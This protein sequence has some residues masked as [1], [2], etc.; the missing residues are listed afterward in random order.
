[1]KNRWSDST[2]D[3]FKARYGPRFG[4]ELALRTYTSRLIGAEPALVLHGGGNTSL[5][6][7]Q[8]DVFGDEL[9]ALF[10]KASGHDLANIEPEGHV[11]VKLAPLQRMRALDDLDDAS[12]EAELR[13]HL[14]DSRAPTPS[15]ETPVHALIPERFVDHAHA[16]AILALTNQPDGEARVA[17]ALGPNVIVLPYVFAGFRLS[18]LVADAREKHPQAVGMIWMHHGIVTW[19]DSARESY[20]RM[21]E[22][23]SRAEAVLE[24]QR[25]RSLTARRHTSLDEAHERLGR[26]APLLRGRLAAPSGDP[27]RP[28]RRVLLLPLVSREV[29]DL[30]DSEGARELC[31]SPPLTADHLIRTKPLPL[32]IDLPDSADERD[33]CALIEEAIEAYAD[34]YRAYLDRHAGSMPEG[35][36]PFDALPR[37][38]LMPGIGAL[39]VGRDARSAAIARDITAQT[40]AAKERITAM[41]VEYR[42]LSEEHLFE[43]E[44]RPLQRAKLPSGSGPALAGHVVLVTGAAGAI[45]SGICEGLLAEGAH[46]VAT[47]LAGPALDALVEKLDAE[48]PGRS[49]GV[50]VDV[51]DPDSVEAGFDA[52]S[53]TWGGV[54]Q[55]IIN[56]GLA[57]VAA[58]EE[59]DLARFQL[60]Q[61]VNTEGALLLLGSAGRRLKQQGTGGDIVLVSTKNVFA[62]GARFGAYSATKAAAHQLARIASQELAE[63]DVRVNMV[64]PDAVFSHGARSSGLWAEVGPDRMQARGLDAAGLEEYYRN[65]NLLQ[66]QIRADHVANAVLFFL[67]RRTPTTGA[68]IPV[69]GGLPDATPR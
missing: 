57:H 24:G 39:C 40:L 36:E 58:L 52:A 5:K 41:G 44:Y 68:T 11:A 25:C 53:R 13:C 4:D 49:V 32:W 18:K 7:T 46:V 27:D 14:F 28:H 45:G 60:L 64:A 50:P 16:D 63:Y 66:A 54:D 20:D 62:P 17:E 23:V 31:V 48:A 67:T 19:G 61:R 56:A 21:I 8:R 26:V 10:I 15:I 35:V 38:V 9:E 69:D 65:R 37:V 55:V 42:G 2:A 29:L 3:E 1:M 59:M 51:T 47:D 33:S 43:M 22:L 30:L 12:M 34:A 6:G